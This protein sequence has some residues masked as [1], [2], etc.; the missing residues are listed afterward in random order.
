MERNE[1]KKKRKKKKEDDSKVS[2]G[3]NYS[4][5][6]SLSWSKSICDLEMDI[7]RGVLQPSASF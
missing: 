4:I 7:T 1:K 5:A 6:S 2:I 3:V